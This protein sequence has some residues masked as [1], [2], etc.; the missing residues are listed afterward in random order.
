MLLE[1]LADLRTVDQ[2]G[3]LTVREVEL[4]LTRLAEVHARWWERPDVRGLSWIRTSNYYGDYFQKRMTENWEASWR[5]IGSSLDAQDEELVRRTA[6]SIRALFQ[7]SAASGSTLVHGDYRAE[8]FLF[9]G[10]GSPD[11]L[12]VLDWQL[13][14]WGSGCR[15]TGYLL[16]QSLTPDVRASQER[17]LLRLYT[18]TLRENG[19]TGYSLARCEEDYR[20]GLLTALTIPFITGNAWETMLVTGPGE[21]DAEAAA[22]W[23]GFMDSGK[24]LVTGMAL[25][26]LAAIHDN[27]AGRFLPEV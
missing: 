27:E 20:R 10:A 23:H 25:R 2:G 4:A 21:V 14:Y 7:Q 6:G 13:V 11:E 26:S 9:G 17:D 18:E 3:G 8:N 22:M 19:V 16:G 5:I 15:D 24:R 12:V 1:D